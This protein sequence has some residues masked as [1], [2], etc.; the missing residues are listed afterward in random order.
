MYLL[1]AKQTKIKNLWSG[2]G[3]GG[4]EMR[5]EES[6]GPWPTHTDAQSNN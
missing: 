3:G 4:G 2:V 5:E 6:V 1:T